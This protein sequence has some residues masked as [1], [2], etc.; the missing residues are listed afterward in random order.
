MYY[1]I[2]TLKEVTIVHSKMF[3]FFLAGN[4]GKAKISNFT[5]F[6]LYRFLLLLHFW[7]YKRSN[8]HPRTYRVLTSLTHRNRYIAY[9]AWGHRWKTF[10]CHRTVQG[11][12]HNCAF[13]GVLIGEGEVYVCICMR[14]CACVVS[15][16]PH[17]SFNAATRCGVSHTERSL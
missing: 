2:F 1:I 7:L 8:C 3:F 9:C 17:K 16:V 12:T 15:W 5:K 14:V 13:V 10:V 6:I 4:W 11:H